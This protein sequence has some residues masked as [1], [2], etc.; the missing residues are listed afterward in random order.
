M[1]HIYTWKKYTHHLY[2]PHPD[3]TSYNILFYANQYFRKINNDW[4]KATFTSID[5][6]YEASQIWLQAAFRFDSK[7]MMVENIR[8][9]LDNNGFIEVDNDTFDKLINL[10]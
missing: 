7:E 10:T 1:K 2:N 4:F 8:V 9:K 5:E 6:E 3:V